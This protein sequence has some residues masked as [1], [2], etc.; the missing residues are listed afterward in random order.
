V[1][2]QKKEPVAKKKEPVAEVVD[3]WDLEDDQ[4]AGYIKVP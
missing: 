4:A 3:D 2:P 1:V